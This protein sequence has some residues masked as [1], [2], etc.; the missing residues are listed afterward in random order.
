MFIIAILSVLI[1]AFSPVLGLIFIIAYS[2]KYQESKKEGLFYLIFLITTLIFLSM[3]I[4]DAVRLSDIIIGIGM[5]SY[6]FFKLKS[7]NFDYAMIIIYVF[8]YSTI[9]GLFR[10]L[11]LGKKLLETVSVAFEQSRELII[12]SFQNNPDQINVFLD[13][14]EK[15]RIFL[16]NFNISIWIA[17]IVAA[18][19]LGALILS[20]RAGSN[21]KHNEIRLPFFLI[22]F[23]IIVLVL[24]LLPKTKVVGL[25]GI[26]MVAPL[27]LIQGISILDF[28]WGN[29]FSK[30]KFL[31]YLLI[32]AMALNLP[33]LVLVSLVGMFDIWFDFRK[34]KITEDVHENHLS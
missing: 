21:W 3:N 12:A 8:L 11:V 1:S 14:L 2:G 32:F 28:Y 23:L 16:E 27:F 24:V 9:Y 26:L 6:L 10:H 33:L 5:A 34:I 17:G 30:S 13:V 19:Y 15:S 31:L 18:T 25:N 7:R 20:K 4:I 29:F 22:Y